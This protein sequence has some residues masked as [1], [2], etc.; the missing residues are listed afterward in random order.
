M[1]R[2]PSRGYRVPAYPTREDGAEEARRRVPLRWRKSRKMATAMALLF[3]PLPG[4]L[5][6]TCPPQ[7]G[8][9]KPSAG[10]D[11]KRKGQGKPNPLA[12][13]FEHGEGRGSFGCVAVAPPAF[14]SEADARQVILEEFAR[15]GVKF[16][17]DQKRHPTLRERS[18]GLAYK[19]G[20]VTATE[21]LGEPVLLD[22]W[23]AAHN[24]GFEYVSHEDYMKL[25]GQPSMSTVQDYDFKAVARR[26][27]DEAKQDGSMRLGVF[28]DP[29][30]R[31]EWERD[32]HGNYHEPKNAR[33]QAQ[34]RA[35]VRDFIAWLRAEGVL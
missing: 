28:Y 34:L 1:K 14:L 26:L 22:G 8:G 27:A 12:G 24:L 7:K 21:K 23:D 35:Q 20:K 13:V 17:L 31:V 9:A 15:A 30:A 25:G 2:G 5:A 4:A 3:F 19:D 33:G 16:Q 10:T 6:D 18:S 11:E 29:M 32:E